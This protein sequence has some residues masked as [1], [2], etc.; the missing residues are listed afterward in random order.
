MHRP[1]IV[2]TLNHMRVVLDTNV[3]IDALSD[4]FNAASRLLDA[5]TDGELEA[6]AT[7]KVKQEYRLIIRREVN[8]HPVEERLDD[9]VNMVDEV[10]PGNVEVVIDDP[11]DIKF[12]EAAV[13]GGAQYIVTSDRH[14][15][16]VGE[17]GAI[18]IITPQEA[19]VKFEEGD[20]KVGGWQDLV[21]NLGIG[22]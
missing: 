18:G 15:L 13:G 22:K 4:D 20:S 11:E 21:K 14:L 9:F 7:R 19:W 1:Y 10:R 5:V 2:Y 8:N 16:D 17:V 6:I 12:I 3:L